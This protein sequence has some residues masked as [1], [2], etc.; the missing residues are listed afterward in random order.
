MLKSCDAAEEEC[1]FWKQVDDEVS[2][3][4]VTCP[5]TTDTTDIHK[6]T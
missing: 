2:K 6:P 1:V 5:I 4:K 3:D